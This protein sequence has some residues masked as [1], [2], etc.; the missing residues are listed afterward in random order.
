MTELRKR[1]G[2]LVQA[3]RRHAG[4]TQEALAEKAGISA[5]MISKIEGGTTG[6]RFPVIERI[7][8]ALDVDPAELFSAD[9]PKGALDRRSLHDV[10]VRLANLSD[11]EL[12]WVSGVV[13]AILRKPS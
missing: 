13:D 11:S 10:T 5:D 8:R 7:A 6:A 2:G 3:H 4:L 1:F 9:I 12:R